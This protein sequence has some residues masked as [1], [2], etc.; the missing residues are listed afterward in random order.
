M[1]PFITPKK[2]RNNGTCAQRT[3]RHNSCPRAQSS[4]CFLSTR[5][6]LGDEPGVGG[7]KTVKAREGCSRSL[8]NLQPYHLPRTQE[9]FPVTRTSTLVLRN[10]L[11]PSGNDLEA[12]VS[13]NRQWTN[14][15]KRKIFLKK[16]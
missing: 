15:K 14:N 2:C 7:N 12:M 9:G 16:I 3:M 10:P 11:N 4:C 13:E 8:S 6:S 1:Q 5:T